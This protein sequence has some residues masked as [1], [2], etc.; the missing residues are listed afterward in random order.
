[1]AGMDFFLDLA[2]RFE[3]GSWQIDNQTNVVQRGEMRR[4]LTIVDCSASSISW[5]IFPGV[6]VCKGG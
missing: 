2:L 1:M 6:W 3:V 5:K 4:L